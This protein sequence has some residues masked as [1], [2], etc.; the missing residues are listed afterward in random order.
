MK[1]IVGLGN[2]GKK[3]ERTRHNAGFRAVRAL[4]TMKADAFDGWKAKFDA[5]ISEGRLGGEKVVLMLPQ[6]FMNNS[7]DAVIQAAQFWKITPADVLVVSD[8]LNLPLGTL[9]LLAR[10]TAG[11]HNGL[12]SV[13]ERLGTEDVP[14]LR[15]GIGTEKTPAVP[16]ETFVLEPF[17]EEE[18][19]IMGQSLRRA[20]EA[21]ETVVTQ[22][23][24]AAQNS[25]NS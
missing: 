12:K 18:E 23:L 22:G 24:I 9:R 3:Y 16:S 25:F 1:L 10:G 4:H 6:T 11:G 5:E 17:T 19:K 13:L 7:G 8:E 14:R 20:A 15:L 2:P 21:I